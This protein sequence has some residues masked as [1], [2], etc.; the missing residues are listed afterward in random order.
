MFQAEG[1]R[2]AE[3]RETVLVTGA[4]GGIGA[5]LARV[6]AKHGSAL[7]LSARSVD[8][9]EQLA[10]ELREKHGTAVRVIAADLAS[11]TG[12]AR[13][14]ERLTQEGVPVDVLVNNA[15]YA[16]Y[17]AFAETEWDDK[18]GML[19]L[20]VV[21]LTELTQRLLPGMLVRQRGGVL[22][23]ASTAAFQP[24]PLMAVYYATKAYVLSFSEA[25]AEEVRGSGVHVTALCPGPTQSGFQARAAME[26]SRLV[27]GRRLMDA[28]TVAQ[29]GYD[30]LRRGAHV[31]IPGLQNRLLAQS[32]RFMPRQLLT[33]IV[34][35]MQERVDA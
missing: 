24:G 6:F 14:V 8:K 30:G 1:L 18:A 26:A 35:R 33:R 10:Q 19:Q 20:N 5:E 3:F 12:V 11:A 2:M 4:S 23:I 16:G 17:G 21:S 28:A 25:L 13:L 29:A 31:V 15:G 9:L 22:N 34:H 27:K 7:V 32:A